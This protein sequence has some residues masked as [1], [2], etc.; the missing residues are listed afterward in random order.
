M[1]HIYLTEYFIEPSFL[2][3][4]LHVIHYQQYICHV[5]V[6]DIFIIYI[7]HKQGCAF[8]P[9]YSE[10]RADITESDH[11]LSGMTVGWYSS[12]CTV[13]IFYGIGEFVAIVE[14]TSSALMMLHYK[15]FENL[16]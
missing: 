2:W 11:L 7:Q 15:M 8:F 1:K 9:E 13:V 14:I 12:C 4:W 10:Y 5:V 3:L 6:M 16:S